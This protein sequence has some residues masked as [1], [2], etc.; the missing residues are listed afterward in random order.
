MRKSDD[1][2]I[3]QVQ[4]SIMDEL[5]DHRVAVGGAG[6]LCE[7]ERSTRGACGNHFMPFVTAR[8][9]GSAAGRSCRT[10][11]VTSS[12]YDGRG[13]EPYG[14]KLLPIDR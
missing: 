12:G 5:R 11:R 8:S 1:M 13:I 6:G 2:K 9:A 14:V 4:E 10:T 7:H 3:M